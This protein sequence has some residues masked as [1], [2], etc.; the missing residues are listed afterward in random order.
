MST[1]FLRPGFRSLTAGFNVQGTSRLL[2][3]L[4]QAFDARERDVHRS[5]DGSVIHG[6]ILIGDSL[7]E[8]SEARLDWPAKTC[9]VHLYVPDADATYER[10]VK[11]G[12]TILQPLED[13]PHGER[14]AAVQDAAGNH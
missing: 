6:E 9:A 4:K 5:P 12:A 7:V 10:A 11:A 1:N 2:D 8:I 3:F 14:A 13:K